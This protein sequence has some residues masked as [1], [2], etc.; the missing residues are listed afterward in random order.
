MWRLKLQNTWENIF[1]TSGKAVVSKRIWKGKY[2]LFSVGVGFDHLAAVVFFMFL[3]CQV[4]LSPH[5]IFYSLEGR[6]YVWFT[7]KGEGLCSP[8]FKAEYSHKVF[9]ILL[10]GRFASSPHLIYLLFIDWFI[11][12]LSVWLRNIYFTLW[13]IIQYCFVYFVAQIVLALAFGNSV[14]LPLCTFGILSSIFYCYFLSLIHF[15]TLQYAPISSSN[16]FYSI[17]RISHF[18]KEH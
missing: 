11:H 5:S 6:Y 14:S 1:A 3:H 15:L 16:L 2:W 18:S 12:F 17:F 10:H 7:L 9:G 13:V 4:M 8:S